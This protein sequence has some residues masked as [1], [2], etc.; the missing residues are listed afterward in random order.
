M[1]LTDEVLQDII[2]RLTPEERKQL[3]KQLGKQVD[4]DNITNPTGK[5]TTKPTPKHKD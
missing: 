3:L 4:I 5:T 1:T 2:G